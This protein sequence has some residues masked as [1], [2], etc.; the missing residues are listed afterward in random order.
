[1]VDETTDLPYQAAIR[2]LLDDVSYS[3][4]MPDWFSPLTISYTER[5]T[6]LRQDV[7]QYRA[8]KK[9]QAPFR[10]DVPKRSGKS[11]VWALPS[12][13]DQIT[14]QAC[15]SSIAMDVEQSS[16]DREKVYSYALNP[17]PNRVAFVEDSM[18]AW[19]RF[20]N[21]V[22][23]RCRSDDCM[24]Q[25]DLKDA[26]E[27]I[28]PEAFFK[29]LRKT[30]ASP[31]TVDMIEVFLT[32]FS[33]P[34]MGLPFLNDSVFFLGNAFLS[35]VDARIAKHTGNF[36]RFA[37]DYK[38]F[39]ASRSQLEVM[40]P[41][42]RESLREIGFELNDSKLKLGPGE[43]YLEAIANAGRAATQK[44]DYIAAT[45]QSDLI[46]PKDMHALIAKALA[47]PDVYLHQGFGRL[48]LGALRRMRVHAEISDLQQLGTSPAEQLAIAI[49]SDKALMTRICDLLEQ[50]SVDDSNGWRLLWLLY[51]SKNLTKT[52]T[53]E[54]ALRQRLED[55][56]LRIRQSTTVPLV[57]R[58]WAASQ[59][60][61]SN[62]TIIEELHALDYIEKG[63]RC[64]ET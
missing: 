60:A 38:I 18:L 39:G 20:R 61:I 15:V 16:I 53:K 45:T 11:N 25:I 8:G 34:G 7:A 51:V 23:G 63:K 19:K 14:L 59:K 42:I 55:I 22:E 40:L 52:A 37:D 10:I 47:S 24:L 41:S 4:A 57:C 54:P 35:E 31:K 1:M 46:D 5:E 27:S 28:K 12:V 56:L 43:A 36:V 49:V 64:N 44:T 26:F 29:F 21:V 62:T 17:D 30:P 58:L 3:N 13:N 48:Q 50:Y 32:A 9:P 6:R 2:L 33:Q